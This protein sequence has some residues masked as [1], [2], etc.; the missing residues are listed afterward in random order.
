MKSLIEYIAKSL[1]D[2]PEEVQVTESGGGLEVAIAVTGHPGVAVTLELAVPSEAEIRG[3]VPLAELRAPMAAHP[4]AH[5]ENGRQ[6]VVPELPRDLAAALG[7][8]L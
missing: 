5:G 4:V 1:V 7:T 3:A 2:H 6:I 8:N